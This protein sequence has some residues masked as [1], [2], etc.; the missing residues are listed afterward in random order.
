MINDPIV[1]DV[2]QARQKILDK[3]EGDLGKWLEH[4]RDSEGCHRDQ[5]VTLDA[6]QT[7]DRQRTHSDEAST[8]KSEGRCDSDPKR[9]KEVLT[10]AWDLDHAL[11]KPEHHE[12]ERPS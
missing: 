4:L 2:Y 12:T 8:Y 9:T 1:E 6:M 5:L 11:E 3:W 10:F 7:I